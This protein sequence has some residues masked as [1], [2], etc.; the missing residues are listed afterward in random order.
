MAELNQTKLLVGCWDEVLQIDAMADAADGVNLLDI[1]A[2]A[3]M[4]D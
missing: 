2:F 3:C 1:Q 4:F